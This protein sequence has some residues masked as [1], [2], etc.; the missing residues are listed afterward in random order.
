LE[1][2]GRGQSQI[3]SQFVDASRL[4][5]VTQATAARASESAQQL[6]DNAG[7]ART[8]A[9]TAVELA[10]SLLAKV[11]T[12]KAELT[13]ATSRD[14]KH[15]TTLIRQ[16]AQALAAARA[17]AARLAARQM[18]AL[19]PI[20]GFPP[21]T[22][23]QGLQALAWAKTQLGVPY[24]WGGGDANGPTLGFAETDGPTDG[25]HTI[26]FDCS[27][28]TLFA[29]AHAG[30]T[31]G[32]WT[33]AQWVQGSAVPTDQIRPGDLL[34]FA[35]DVNDPTTIHHVGIYA[36]NAQMIDAPE[37]GA[38]VRYDPAFNDQF[39]GAIRP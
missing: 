32:H 26:G 3:V 19:A 5:A 9:A 30:Y 31:L 4:A 37:T 17:A 1:Q 39:I 33:G 18:Q 16:R 29:W 14:R 21:A 25:L 36:G 11:E 38:V 8:A 24:S 35:T 28:L 12:A 15:V 10:Q 27:G 34:F 7:A 2:I 20:T 6:L 13:A 23:Q 22:P